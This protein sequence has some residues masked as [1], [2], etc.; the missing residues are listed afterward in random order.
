MPHPAASAAPARARHVEP[1]VPSGVSVVFAAL[2]VGLALVRFY[3][4]RPFLDEPHAFRQAWTSAYA[5]EFYRF[6]MN[7]FRPSIIAMGNYRH[8]LIEFP[9][10][11]WLTAL[12]YHATG[13]TLIVDRLLS[14]TFFFGSAYFLFRA[15]ELVQDRLFAWIVALIY[16]GA[17]LGIYFSRA[18]HID[19]AALC[20]GHALLYYF[21]RYGAEGRRR[22]LILASIASALGLLIKAPYVFYLILPALYIQL[23][24]GHRRRAAMSAIAFGVA[25]MLGVAW[26]LYAQSV[27]R[28]APDLS[29][30]R[31]YETAADRLDFYLGSAGRRLNG[32]EWATIGTRIRREIAANVWWVLVP[33]GLIWRRHA[34]AAWA[35]AAVWSLSSLLFL[36][37]F[38]AANSIHNYYQLAFVAPFALW[39]AIPLYRWMRTEGS[40]GRALRP[41]A[42]V[43]IAAYAA[44][45][46]RFAT[47][48]YYAVDELGVRVG[49]FV[50]LRTTDRDL[51]IMAFNDAYNFDPRYLYYADRRGWSVHAPWLEPRAIVGLRAQ[52]ATAVVTSEMWP[53]PE[54]TRRYLD[55]QRLIGIL[56][57]GDKR[58]FLHRI[59]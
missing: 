10:P 6:D 49:Q 35:F 21:L 31:G 36:L 52:G 47:G 34:R 7:I 2:A 29:F 17:P 15:V 44:T 40:G 32:Q 55:G 51:V 58:V 37:L 9:V 28:Q 5:L 13:P 46:V 54:P 19:S 33:L 30:V 27:N 41:L 56:N 23:A 8:I 4:F 42:I 25:L 24:R 50:R 26:F 3:K 12:I 18:I 1:G 43:L 14:M 48:N 38:F 39:M 11:E 53:A 22:D 57:V 45:G 59:D 16:M 20:F